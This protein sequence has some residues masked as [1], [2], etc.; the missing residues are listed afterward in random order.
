[1][2]TYTNIT[3]SHCFSELMLNCRYVIYDTIHLYFTYKIE[4]LTP[5]H[6]IQQLKI[7]CVHATGLETFNYNIKSLTTSEVFTY[8]SGKMF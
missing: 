8:T 4:Q 5:P 1:M 3:F 2:Y 6:S 7:R